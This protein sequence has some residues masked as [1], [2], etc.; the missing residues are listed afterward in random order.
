MGPKD[1]RNL[2]KAQSKTVFVFIS[3]PRSK[4]IRTFY[5][6]EF[7]SQEQALGSKWDHLPS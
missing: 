1:D 3:H 4:S 7:C 2:D 6:Q 5:G